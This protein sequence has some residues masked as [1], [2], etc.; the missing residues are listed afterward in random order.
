[1]INI[2]YFLV[3]HILSKL[4]L[5]LAFFSRLTHISFQHVCFYPYVDH[6]HHLSASQYVQPPNNPLRNPKVNLFF[7]LFDVHN[8]ASARN[9]SFL[10]ISLLRYPKANLILFYSLVYDVHVTPGTSH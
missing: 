5:S 1:M 8:A 2:C 7:F 9:I 10:P 3:T 4:N 6:P